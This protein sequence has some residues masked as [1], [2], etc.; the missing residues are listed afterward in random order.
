MNHR[1]KGNSSSA[2]K[3]RLSLSYRL[4]A[5]NKPGERIDHERN[6]QE[7]DRRTDHPS[8]QNPVV[9]QLSD[10]VDVCGSKCR[11]KNHR[12]QEVIDEACDKIVEFASK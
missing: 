7:V 3:H 5:K 6:D 9:V 4:L 11:L 12:H 2:S 10:I 1:G 8:V